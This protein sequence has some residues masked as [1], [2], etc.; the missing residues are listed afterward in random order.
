MIPG[1]RLRRQVLLGLVLWLTLLGQSLADNTLI[2]AI[3]NGPRALRMGARLLVN[4]RVSA[5]VASKEV[6]NPAI[7]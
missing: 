4:E 2:A 5:A 7:S 1:G 6:S 3:L